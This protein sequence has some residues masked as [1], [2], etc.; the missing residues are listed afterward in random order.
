MFPDA[1]C[2][3]II[4]AQPVPF[5]TSPFINTLHQTRLYDYNICGR[6]FSVGVSYLLESRICQRQGFIMEVQSRKM[7]DGLCQHGGIQAVKYH[8]KAGLKPA[9]PD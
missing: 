8:L 4:T 2:A 7:R 9:Y 5:A 6:I 1:F 3:D